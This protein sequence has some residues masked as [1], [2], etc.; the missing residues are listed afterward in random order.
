MAGMCPAAAPHGG[1]L[2]YGGSL[3]QG[4]VV[5]A[6]NKQRLVFQ[7]GHGLFSGASVD[8]GTLLLLRTLD[9]AE[10]EG[11]ERVADLGCGYGPLGIALASRTGK[12]AALI[13][14]DAVAVAYSAYNAAAN[15]VEHVS[16]QPGLGWPDAPEGPDRTATPDL[17]VSNIPAKAGPE[18]IRAMLLGGDP[19]SRRAVVVIER[20]AD[21][22]EAV[23]AGVG[24][25]VT[26]RKGNRRHLALHYRLADRSERAGVAGPGPG[27]T[28]SRGSRPFASGRLA[29]EAETAWGLPEFDT[30]SRSTKLSIRLLRGVHARPG[31][32]AMVFEPGVGHLAVVTGRLIEPDHMT[33]VSRDLLSLRMSAANAAA[34]AVAPAALAHEPFP[35]ADPGSVDLAVVALD[36]K[37]P[38]PA[39]AELARRLADQTDTASRVLVAGS[40]TV[41][42]RFAAAVDSAKLPL[43]PLERVKDKGDAAAD[44]VRR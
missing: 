26:L 7:V 31:T 27:G 17:L 42:Q 34:E 9:S 44:F 19:R 10:L 40:S 23:L 4:E 38:A 24:A 18:T 29:W 21:E 33:L 14:R 39:I 16:T 15:S 5:L 41:V 8:I 30:L 37:L 28:S 11:V 36:A 2:P 25:E 12:S 43:L 32:R 22:V 6:Q 20:I 1:E 3:Q 13:D 35:V